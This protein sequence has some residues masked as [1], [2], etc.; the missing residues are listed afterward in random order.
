MDHWILLYE[1]SWSCSVTFN[2]SLPSLGMRRRFQNQEQRLR[3][4][5]PEICRIETA[6]IR[7]EVKQ[8]AQ[9]GPPS[10]FARDD[11]WTVHCQGT[12]KLQLQESA[13]QGLPR[14]W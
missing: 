10:T 5:D 9:L 6:S 7:A 11:T 4:R 2:I 1:L 8:G 14:V 13:L 3:R 12:S